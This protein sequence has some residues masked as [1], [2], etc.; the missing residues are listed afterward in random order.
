MNA[1]DVARKYILNVRSR[2]QFYVYMKIRNEG[3]N[4]I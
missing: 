3:L 2:L 1:V 4:F